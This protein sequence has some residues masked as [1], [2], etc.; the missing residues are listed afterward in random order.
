MK[1]PV[2]F[3]N[4][5]MN[6]GPTEARAYMAAFLRFFAPH[7]DRTV[8]LFPP[9]LSLTT[10]RDARADR[11]DILL[12]VQNIHSQEK[13]AFTG[14]NSAP[15]ARDAGAQLAL[16]GHSERRHVFGETDAECARKTV[17]AAKF[18]LIPVLCVGETLA[19]REMGDAERVVVEQLQAVFDEIQP[20]AD[21]QIAI[22]YEP[23]WAIGTGRSA[24]PADASAMHAVIRAKLSEHPRMNPDRIPILYG[25]SVNRGNAKSLLDAD[26]V[27]GLL[28]GGA[29]LD[30]EGWA[31][32]CRT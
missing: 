25:G 20:D 6:H 27:D 9:A 14:E 12:G 11:R 4:W 7:E 8:A 18:G 31:E 29:C 2:F 24:T 28:V 22:A 30:P 10:V 16:V 15:M 32:I 3:A 5:K 19:Q 23:V 26:G 13:G 21:T 17:I 1:R